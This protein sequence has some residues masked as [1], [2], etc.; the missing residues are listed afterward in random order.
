ML[1][2]VSSHILLIVYVIISRSTYS[3]Y[4][5]IFNLKNKTK[6]RKYSPNLLTKIYFAGCSS[7]TRLSC[8]LI[9]TDFVFLLQATILW[10]T[11]SKYITKMQNPVCACADGNFSCLF[12]YLTAPKI[13]GHLIQDISLMFTVHE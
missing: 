4:M 12:C 6:Q 1:D 13:H 10:K 9:V 8:A 5:S 7:L 3:S 11:H 2:T